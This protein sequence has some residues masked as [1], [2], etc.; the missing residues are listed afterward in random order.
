[1]LRFRSAQAKRWLSLGP[2]TT[3][4]SVCIV[5][6]LCVSIVASLR[7]D[8][9]WSIANYRAIVEAGPYIPILANTL[10]IALIVTA[11]SVAASLPACAFFAKKSG[12][13]VA[14]FLTILGISFTISVLVR[15]YA[16]E[17][18]LAYHGLFNNLVVAL[19]V[20]KERQYLLYTKLA[21]VLAMV[22]IMIPYAAL[23][24]FAGMRRIDWDFVL[25]ARTLGAN[26]WV[27]FRAAYWPQN[28]CKH[29][30][31]DGRCVHYFDGL[32]RDASASRWPGNDHD[33]HADA[34]GPRVQL[35]K[36]R[37]VG[38]RNWGAAAVG[39]TGGHWCG[40]QGDRPSIPRAGRRPWRTEIMRRPIVNRVS[41]AVGWG[42]AGALCAF[43]LLPVVI[44]V[45]A[46]FG[47]ADM[48][49]FP[50]AALSLRWYREVLGDG[51]WLSS[52]AIS[53]QV[54]VLAACLAVGTGLF[55]G[56]GHLRWGRIGS[57]SASF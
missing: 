53:A 3:L 5:G 50:P 43:L 49:E 11:T 16:W 25:A 7:H 47:A 24:I 19:G 21:V 29:H 36:R 35:R 18:I 2:A 30:D 39:S 57:D 22:Q 40:S 37:R 33:R 34:V 15:T 42:Y 13:V 44:I 45:P 38:G 54:A 55:A 51:E 4:A 6:P 28:P 52:A 10:L 41:D 12:R 9:H 56:I 20:A 32:F 26:W 17:V 8:G 23:V 14:S 27:T 48:L 46:S 1:M 31:G